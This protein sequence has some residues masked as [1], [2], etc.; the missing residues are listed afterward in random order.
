MPNETTLS[1][2]LSSRSVT[3][4]AASAARALVLRGEMKTALLDGT[5]VSLPCDMW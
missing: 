2:P 3:S 1:W 5:T 4:E